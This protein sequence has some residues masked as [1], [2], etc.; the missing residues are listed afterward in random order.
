M[1]P[2][3]YIDSVVAEVV[4]D[5]LRARLKEE[6]GEHWEDYCEENAMTDS[7]ENVL[8]NETLL[9]RQTNAV[10]TPGMLGRD[11]LVSIVGGLWTLLMIAVMS[12]YFVPDIDAPE[13]ILPTLIASVMG[14]ALW[15]VIAWYTYLAI[16]RRFVTHYGQTATRTGLLVVAIA[17]PVVFFLVLSLVNLF[18]VLVGVGRPLYGG[19]W[20]FIGQVL[21][22]LI[23]STIFFTAGR[24]VE[25]NVS[26]ADRMLAWLRHSTPFIVA[27]LVAVGVAVLVSTSNQDTG[28]QEAV[29]LVAL[30]LTLPL[31]VLYL[32]WGMVS[33]S[34]GFLLYFI[35][36]PGILG[37][38]LITFSILA[39]SVIWPIALY[40]SKHRVSTLHK[41]MAGIFMP[42]A[43]ILPFLSK[44]VP[45]TDWQVPVVWSWEDVER[46]QLN[47]VYPWAEPLMRRNDGMNVSYAA[48]V[49]NGQLLV[50][51]RRGYSYR[52]TRD[53]VESIGM[54]SEAEKLMQDTDGYGLKNELPAGFACNGT[55]L[56]ELANTHNGTT[57]PLGMFGEGCDSLSYL[58]TEILA[59][60][61]SIIDL[62]L[63]DD[64]LLA[65]SI[66]MGSYDPTYVY[67]VDL[68]ELTNK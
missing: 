44:D 17:L 54:D 48:H 15:G 41:I 22:I 6:L 33:I 8:G 31:L 25:R 21:P 49:E 36:L 60:N 28:L 64:G 11:I 42:L 61:H 66:N 27:V 16:H 62:D 19:V 23:I 7:P 5:E 50:L 10:T 39:A 2:E 35:G 24:L 52:V 29:T 63:A 53:G 67:V 40:L 3:Q 18:G 12:M 4:D 37:F 55:P 14:I 30:P 45:Q 46:K 34:A 1:K 58:G 43:I 51:Q 20:A 26:Q 68:A 32:L 47:I 13:Q 65:V 57:G 38:W 59:T 9:A 56:E